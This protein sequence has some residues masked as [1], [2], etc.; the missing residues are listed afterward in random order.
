MEAAD[1]CRA[2]ANFSLEAA[3]SKAVKKSVRE[4]ILS[5]VFVS[6]KLTK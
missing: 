1:D 5:L 4:A 2:G 3:A 6:V